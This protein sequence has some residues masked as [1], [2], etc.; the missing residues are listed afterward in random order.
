ME[1]LG[2]KQQI[3]AGLFNINSID[4]D[5]NTLVSAVEGRWSRVNTVNTGNELLNQ[6]SASASQLVAA[7]NT[8][9]GVLKPAGYTGPVV[10]V[11]TF[12]AMIA[13]NKIDSSLC[14]ASD[15]S[16]ANAHAF[17]DSSIVASGAGAWLAQTVKDIAASCPGKKV[18]ITESGW[19]SAGTAN[20]AA[21]PKLGNQQ[22][23]ISSIKSA[24][25]GNGLILFSAYN[26]LWK[27]NADWN[28]FAEQ[29]YGIYGNCPSSE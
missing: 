12:N 13:Q 9:K 1:D 2:T 24:V 10:Y 20:G 21:V 6:G 8:A 5:A 3:F 27:V 17:F 16:A 29:S 18:V 7:I 19:P 22:T 15:Y 11:D 25:P 28:F 26:D 23:A 4:A 14:D